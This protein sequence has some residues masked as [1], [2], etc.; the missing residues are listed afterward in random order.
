MAD[1]DMTVLIVDLAGSH[2][3]LEQMGQ[4]PANRLIGRLL[5]GIGQAIE[6]YGGHVIRTVG[7]EIIAEFEEPNP[8]IAAAIHVQREMSNH[9]E[10]KDRGLAARI[11]MFHGPVTHAESDVF[12][13]TV[14]A[15]RGITA[16]AKRRQILLPHLLSVWSNIRTPMH[17]LGRFEVSGIDGDLEIAEVD[18]ASATPS[19]LARAAGHQ[20][21]RVNEGWLI[22]SAHAD[23]VCGP[24]KEL[25]SIG[26]KPT[27]DIILGFPWVS[28]EHTTLRFRGTALVL[29]DQSRNGT[30]VLFEAI[31]GS[32][33]A[34]DPP[35]APNQSADAEPV[36]G[37]DAM[38]AEGPHPLADGQDAGSPSG[39][40][41]LDQ[42]VRVVPGATAPTPM[43]VKGR[44]MELR[45]S[46]WLG[47]GR[48]MSTVETTVYFSPYDPEND[49]RVEDIDVDPPV[50]GASPVVGGDAGRA[51]SPGPQHVSLRADDQS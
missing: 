49:P 34:M 19:D 36:V 17:P 39:T 40:A 32:N 18:W 3:L 10:S 46:G 35:P 51:R 12:G 22:E 8:A 38:T 42:T 43:L 50:V 29:E 44:T 47:I 14:T 31:G 30:W 37:G 28:R 33:D 2:R 4:A 41:G 21:P 48:G 7:D 15:A 5:G 16:L 23:V 25:V 6:Y 26:R 27:A 9:T 1:S 13:T 45:G 11:G 20:P 24:H